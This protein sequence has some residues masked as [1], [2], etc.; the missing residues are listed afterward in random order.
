MV[1]GKTKS[2]ALRFVMASVISFST[3][4]PQRASAQ[5]NEAQSF[6]E[7]I[8]GDSVRLFCN[9]NYYLT[10]VKC[11]NI[12]RY[13][14]MTASGEFQGPF[15]DIRSDSVLMA[16]GYYREG[17]K[18]GYFEEYYPTGQVRSKGSYK[19]DKP[20]NDWVFFFENGL[21]ERTIR[22]TGKDTLLILLTT[23]KGNILV[24]QGNGTFLARVERVASSPELMAK[25]SIENGKRTGDWRV[26][27]PTLNIDYVKE[28]FDQ[29]KFV[30]GELSGLKKAYCCKS[31]FAL[32]Y[33]PSY[34]FLEKFKF[35]S[36][37]ENQFAPTQNATLKS[38]EYFER[39]ILTTLDDKH[40]I[41]DRDYREDIRLRFIVDEEGRPKDFEI[42]SGNSFL[43]NRIIKLLTE[44]IRWDPAMKLK[45]PVRQRKY[46]DIRYV[47]TGSGFAY[48]YN[49]P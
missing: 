25:G 41:N 26:Y 6:Y 22:F 12:S 4:A 30:K 17:K 14:R 9:L 13:C 34:L 47:D 10:S 45:V 48:Q 32:P 8:S 7:I 23:E 20:V 27:F 29:G 31:N 35:S 15:I 33:T 28:T 36:C 38:K 11:A 49:Y 24:S 5:S 3:I 37:T 16:K 43:A 42:I 1:I 21:P 18:E 46:F 44:K 39:M 40:N 2:F 19:D